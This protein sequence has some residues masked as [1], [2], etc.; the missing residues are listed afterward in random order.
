M[1]KYSYVAGMEDRGLEWLFIKIIPQ[2]GT[3]IKPDRTTD[4]SKEVS[5][6]FQSIFGAGN[7]YQVVILEN[8]II[9]DGRG[10]FYQCIYFYNQNDS[11]RLPGDNIRFHD[12]A[13]DLPLK[14][15]T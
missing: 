1:A 12:G 8:Y 14:K 15:K 10:G 13:Q 2:F 6:A 3:D 11:R 5:G 4:N 7:P 9:S